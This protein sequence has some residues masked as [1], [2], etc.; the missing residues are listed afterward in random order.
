MEVG[1][2]ILQGSDEGEIRGDKGK[3]REMGYAHISPNLP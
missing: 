1:S 2:G 3:S